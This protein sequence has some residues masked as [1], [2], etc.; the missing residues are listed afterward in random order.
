M[1]MQHQPPA[2]QP[3]DWH[4]ATAQS[5][6]SPP[7]AALAALLLVCATLWAF[8]FDL[9]RAA[10]PTVI[11]VSLDGFHPDYLA[12]DSAATL[13]ELGA[14]GVRAEFLKPIFPTK[15]FPNHYTLV[16]GRYAENHGIVANTMQDA[17][18][19]RFSLGRRAA[20]VD[21]R[22]WD[23]AEPIWITLHKAGIK[24]AMFFWPGSEAEINGIRPAYY[25]TFST[26]SLWDARINWVMDALKRGAPER[27]QLISLYFEEVDTAGH[28]YGPRGA[29][30]RQAVANVDRYLTH[31]VAR[32]KE[33][34]LFDNVNLI[35]TSDH[36][37]AATSRDS[38]V[39]LDDFVDLDSVVVT[40]WDPI[41]AMD[42]AGGD[43][44][45]LL[46]DL[47]RMP[48][49]TFHKK[50]ELP[51]R[52][53]YN[54]HERIRSI[55]GIAEVGWRISSRGYF[56]SNPHR[57]DGGNHGY[58]PDEPS[59][60]GIFIGRGPAFKTGKV[61][62]GFENVHIYALLCA[63]FDVEPAENDGNL[64][65]VRDLLK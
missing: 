55:I 64:D 24:S 6:R 62:A 60:H 41:L 4:K 13:N 42:P 47:Q 58:D 21:G 5:R 26:D 14:E 11:L 8:Q 40:D 39:F 52:L 30:T 22:W 33:K 45:D 16:T 20:V 59:M 57:F 29:G 35:V 3:D 44:D 23:D 48:H 61:V 25:R 50:G 28:A 54:S 36:G 10:P 9:F 15:T 37:M 46:A 31:L 63:I 53:H 65:A 43:T 32:L 17:T 56:N 18:L 34:N 19:G 27:P 49:V 12:W 38:V 51:E 2:P 7:K 1:H